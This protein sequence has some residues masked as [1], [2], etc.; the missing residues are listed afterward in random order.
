MNL[1]TIKNRIKGLITFFIIGLVISGLTAIPLLYELTILND[2]SSELIGSSHPITQWLSKVL[3]GLKYTYDKYPFIAYGTDWLAFAH[4]VIAVAFIGPYR[5]P[6]RNKW[7]IEFG[8]IA[9][10]MVIP[11][12][13]IAGE[14]RDIPIFWRAIDCMFGITGFIPLWIVYKYIQILENNEN[15][16]EVKKTI[17]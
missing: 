8:M 11:F 1:P 3:Q 13:L 17:D 9:C 12:A 14:F 7:V 15:D 5:D 4:L 16:S 10:A 2:Y 6:V